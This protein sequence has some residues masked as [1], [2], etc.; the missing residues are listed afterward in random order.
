MLRFF[1]MS[2]MSSSKISQRWW[3]VRGAFPLSGRTVGCEIITLQDLQALRIFDFNCKSLSSISRVVFLFYIIESPTMA[4]VPFGHF[5]SVTLLLIWAE[6]LYP[7]DLFLCGRSVWSTC[8]SYV[9]SR[10]KKFVCF[11]FRIS[12]NCT[13]SFLL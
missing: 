2:I 10:F 11:S 5:T 3:L 7:F 13:C 8:S 6:L 4:I 12:S 9:L 1:I